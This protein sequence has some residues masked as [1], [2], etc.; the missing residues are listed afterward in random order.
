LYV[1]TS[2]FDPEKNALE[3]EVGCGL[4]LRSITDNVADLL[5]FTGLTLEEDRRT[6]QGLSDALYAEGRAIWQN[7]AGTIALVDVFGG[8]GLL[9]SKAAGEWVSVGGLT[10]ISA[11]PLGVSTVRPDVINLTYRWRNAITPS[12]SATDYEEVL[13]EYFLEHPADWLAEV[14]DGSGGTTAQAVKRNYAVSSLQTT[15]KRYGG[16]GGQV[17]YERDE[18]SGPAVEIAGQY[19]SDQFERCRGV[20]DWYVN[21]GDP[22][23]GCQPGGLQRVLQSYSERAYT[24]GP[25]GEVV[26]T[27]ESQYRNALSCAVPANW[28]PGASLIDGNIVTVDWRNLPEDK[29]FLNSRT[30]TR[31]AYYSDRTVQETETWQSPCN[32]NNAGLD[33]GDI[34]ASAGSKRIERRTSRSRLAN[35]VQPDRAPTVTLYKVE[36]GTAQDLRGPGSFEVG[37]SGAGPVTLQLQSPAELEGPAAAAAASASAFL[38]YARRLLEGDAGGLRVSEALRDEVLAGYRPGMPFSYCDPG[39]TVSRLRMNATSW[40]LNA[41]EVLFSTDGLF[42]GLSD[43][44]LSVG[45]NTGGSVTPPTITGEEVVS[46]GRALAVLVKLGVSVGIAGGVSTQSAP[47]DPV[48]AT[49]GIRQGLTV[50]GQMVGPVGLLATTATGGL[51][52]ASN[53][54]NLLTSSATV[55]DSD[56]FS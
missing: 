51:P 41:S 33:A 22:N 28:Q 37:A 17:S 12:N 39:G 50:S 16:P 5:H 42:V 10:A 54:A 47:P 2:S 8:D 46:D 55:L 9:G 30:I 38:L 34:N 27:V 44:T 53:G 14:P 36:T 3:L 25:A 4:Y 21:R 7:S 20:I 1:V 56:L 40:A 29:L 31:Y 19:F 23:H 18:R 15:E 24:Y 49:A 43:G 45:G 11:Q 32:C 13:S 26:E 35:P 52:V 6:F 48:T